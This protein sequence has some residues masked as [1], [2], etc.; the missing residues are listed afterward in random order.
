[1]LLTL[2]SPLHKISFVWIM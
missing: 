2:A 1:M